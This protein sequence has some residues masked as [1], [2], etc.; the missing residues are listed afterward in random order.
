MQFLLHHA[1]LAVGVGMAVTA[2]EFEGVWVRLPE[3]KRLRDAIASLNKTIGEMDEAIASLERLMLTEM[4]I[5]Y[6]ES[7]RD[8]HLRSKD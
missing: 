8:A 4:L 7:V 1:S 6:G 2:P 3:E 5:S